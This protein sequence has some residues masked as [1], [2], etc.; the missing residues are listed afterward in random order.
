M[1]FKL[2]TESLLDF[3]KFL[4]Y[5][6]LS[7]LQQV[8]SQFFSFIQQYRD[9][10]AL[11]EFSHL[12]IISENDVRLSNY[13]RA[14]DVVNEVEDRYGS[15]VYNVELNEEQREKLIWAAET[16]M[17]LYLS[18]V[19][20]DMSQANEVDSFLIFISRKDVDNVQQPQLCL[21]LPYYPETLSDFLYTRFWLFQL[22]QCYF[23][24][25]NFSCAVFNP[26][27]VQLLFCYFT[28]G[29]DLLGPGLLFLIFTN[30]NSE[31]LHNQKLKF[32]FSF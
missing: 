7:V 8:N 13:R 18:E 3:L 23:D 15:E 26:A 17:P 20:P 24:S 2:P 22:S 11:K 10:L 14:V 32:C 16:Q 4:D 21:E 6:N 19:L 29:A 25:I 5:S 9:E 1:L 28:E 27:I 30:F 31:F 12:E